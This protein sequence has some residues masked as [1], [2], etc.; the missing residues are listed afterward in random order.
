MPFSEVVTAISLLDC[1]LIAIKR[2][3]AKT[4]PVMKGGVR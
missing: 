4:P 3:K 2:L 1:Y